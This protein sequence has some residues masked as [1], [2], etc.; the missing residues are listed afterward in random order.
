[1]NKYKNTKM[2]VSYMILLMQT[3]GKCKLTDSDETRSL[4]F[5]AGRESQEWGLPRSTGNFGG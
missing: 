3:S 5:W 1:M 2:N 4:M